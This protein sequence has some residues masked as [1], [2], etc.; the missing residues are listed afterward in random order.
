M[1]GSRARITSPH[2][3]QFSINSF[4]PIKI[5]AFPQAGQVFF[6]AFRASDIPEILTVFVFPGQWVYLEPMKTLLALTLFASVGFS[7]TLIEGIE[8]K[9]N[10]EVS[11]TKL[12]LNGAALRTAT[13][14]KVKVYAIGLYVAER[15]YKASDIVQAKTPKLVRMKFLR[16][17]DADDI[18]K[19]WNKTFD[20]NCKTDCEELKPVQERF[21]AWM[22][23]LKAGDEQVFTFYGP[24]V[25]YALNGK[26]IGTLENDK[27]AKLLLGS[28]IGDEPPTEAVRDGLLGKSK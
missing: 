18:Q 15:A 8:F 27:F 13:I 5:G 12:L 11:K 10:L 16:D 19:S 14:F 6:K 3:G 24:K 22:S 9:E 4:H 28:W 21:A 17:V 25:T 20:K 2:S 26:T 7:S 23:V 1:S